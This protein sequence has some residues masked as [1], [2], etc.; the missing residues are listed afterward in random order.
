MLHQSD[1]R[2]RDCDAYVEERGRSWATGLEIYFRVPDWQQGLV[3]QAEVG[4]GISSVDQCWGT[5]DGSTPRLDGTGM[6]SFELG[7]AGHST[8]DTNVV[9]CIL[10]GVLEGLKRDV[11]VVYHGPHCFSLPPPPPAG[12]ERCDP[13]K[14]KFTVQSSWGGGNVGR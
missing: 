12:F 5:L 13:Y 8:K 1:R 6:L 9:G 2:L 14:W 11:A 4:L 10:N 7:P 3:V